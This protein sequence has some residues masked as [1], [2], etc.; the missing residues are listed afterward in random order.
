M[1]NLNTQTPPA[2]YL[3]K[4]IIWTI[5]GCWPFGI[6][7]IINAAKVYKLWA[8]GQYDAALAASAAAKKW[9]NV[10]MIIGIVCWALYL[11]YILFW[12]VLF[13]SLL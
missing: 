9:S 2:N 7:A 4:S 11:L 13:E 3:V 5:F 10:T 12:I 8:A 6:P 1:E